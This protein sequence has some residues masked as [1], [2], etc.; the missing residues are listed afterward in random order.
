M[1]RSSTELA[2][3]LPVQNTS[4]DHLIY[5]EWS[6]PSEETISVE[7]AVYIP[8]IFG[9]LLLLGFVG[10]GLVVYVV[11][12]E[13]PLRSVTNVYLLSLA[14]SDLLSFTISLPFTAALYVLPSWPFG[15]TMCKYKSIYSLLSFTTLLLLLF[16]AAVTFI[17][18]F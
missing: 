3:D 6:F 8:I 7:E 5:D 4:Q 9:A 14:I 18:L 11:L 16:G 13:G 12:R 15:D 17:I 2:S 1:F 10:N